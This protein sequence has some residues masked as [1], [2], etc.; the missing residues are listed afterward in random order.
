[1][2]RSNAKTPAQYIAQL[3]E[4][5]RDTISE[6]RD[7]VLRN[8]PKGYR[9]SMNWGML[10]YEIPLERYPETYNGQPL[11]YVGLASQKNY[12]TLYLMGA[13]AVPALAA[14]LENAFR[15][16]GKK[17]DMGKSCLHFRKM[18]DLEQDVLA[19]IIAAVPVEKYIEHYEASRGKTEKKK[20]EVKARAAKTSTAKGSATKK[21]ATKGSTKKGTARKSAAKKSAAR[22]RASGASSLR[23]K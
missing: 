10:S 3:P 20:R 11:G 15:D 23:R 19:E 9:E 14:K 13:Y 12:I 18:E 2:A 22:Q 8:L 7:L 5:R 21:S 16:A 4:D 17:F 1:M 6:V